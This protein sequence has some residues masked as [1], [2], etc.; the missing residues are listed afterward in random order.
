MANQAINHNSVSQHTHGT[1]RSRKFARESFARISRSVFELG[2]GLDLPKNFVPLR[3]GLGSLT[4]KIR[5][6]ILTISYYYKIFLMMKV[7]ILRIILMLLM[8][9]FTLYRILNGFRGRGWILSHPQAMRSITKF[10]DD[11]PIVIVVSS[12]TRAVNATQDLVSVVDTS[13]EDHSFWILRNGNEKIVGN[14]KCLW[15]LLGLWWFH[16]PQIHHHRNHNSW[17]PTP[18]FSMSVSWAASEQINP[19]I[20]IWWIRW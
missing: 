8:I 9:H 20:T 10:N 13:S 12:S 16:P 14:F 7:W 5:C 15:S 1:A 18:D 11:K 3:S 6:S 19:S 2:I 17:G 4:N